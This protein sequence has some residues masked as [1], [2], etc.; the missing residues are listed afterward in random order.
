MAQPQKQKLY[1]M[2]GILLVA[3]YFGSSFVRPAQPTPSAALRETTMTP[4]SVATK[5]HDSSASRDVIGKWRAVGPVT[6]RGTCTLSLELKNSATP[7]EALGYPT[8]DCVSLPPMEFRSPLTARAD[9]MRMLNSRVPTSAV[10]ST[11]VAQGDLQF[12]IDEN[13]GGPCP[14]TAFTV[15]PFG[16]NQIAAEWKDACGGGQMILSKTR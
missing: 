1:W 13:V 8:L 10:L 2:L 12:H 9:A 5:S 15:T 3:G 14:F 11:R 16:T 4:P 6:D 7:G